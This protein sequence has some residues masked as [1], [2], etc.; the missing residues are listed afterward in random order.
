[1]KYLKNFKFQ[2]NSKNLVSLFKVLLIVHLLVKPG[3]IYEKFN[4]EK[5]TNKIPV[6]FL[7]RFYI[8]V[9]I[10]KKYRFVTEYS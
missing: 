2:I 5:S 1:M 10:W 3:N 6:R 9:D 4:K 8:K 7:L